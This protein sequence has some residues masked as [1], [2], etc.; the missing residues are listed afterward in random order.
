MDFNCLFLGLSH[1][2][3]DSTLT[4][5]SSYYPLIVTLTTNGYLSVWSCATPHHIMS[6]LCLFTADELAGD[7]I[8]EGM[9]M[10]TPMRLYYDRINIV[11][12]FVNIYL[13]INYLFLLLI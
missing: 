3:S 6:K 10:N 1:P 2:S 11:L 9:Y 13:I 12:N 7:T 8:V 4:A 5:N